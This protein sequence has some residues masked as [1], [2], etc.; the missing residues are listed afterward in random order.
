[1]ETAKIISILKSYINEAN[2]IKI[3]IFVWSY[4]I[5]KDTHMNRLKCISAKTTFMGF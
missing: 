5:C 3:S 2:C 4:V 1:M